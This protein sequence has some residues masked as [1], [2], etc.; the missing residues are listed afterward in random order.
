MLDRSNVLPH[1]LARLAAEEPDA[2]A[3]QDVDGRVQTRRELHETNLRWADA[4]RRLAVQPGEHVVT[5]L[6][7]SFEAFHAWLGLTWIGAVEVPAN[8]MYRGQMLRYLID[9]SDARVLIIS[10]RFVP[11]LLEVAADLA[12]L[13]TVVVPDATVELP[14]LEQTL[15]GRVVRGDEFFAG[16]DPAAPEIAALPGPEYWDIAAIIYTSG[17]TGPSKGVLMP[18]GTLWSFVTTAPDDFVLPG[19]GFYAMYPAFHVSGKAMLYQASVFRARMV[20][21]EQFSIQHFW[22]DVRRFDIAGAGLVGAMAPFLML[23]PE[24]PDDAT[25]PLR[26]VMMGPLVPQVDDF[27]R[28]FGVNVGTGYGMTEIG[29]P[30]ASD[31][32][33]LA[34]ARSCG[35]LR[36]G[37][38]GYEVRIVDEHDQP[39]GPNTPGELVVRT[40][41]PWVINAGYYGKPEATADAWRNGWFHTGDAFVY[42]DDANFYFVDRIKDAIRRRG[43]NISS[44][45][46]EALV[47]QHP[48]VTESAAIGVP[49]EYLED[50][51]KVCVVRVAGSTLTEAELIEFL[52]PHMPKFM[53]PRYVELVDALPKTEGTMRT[54]KYQLRVGALND[55]T[56]DR[57]AAAKTEEAG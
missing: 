31:G 15:G 2:I 10:E 25:T 36:A 1:L 19:E 17:T 27:K 49:S 28:R 57:E 40:R 32:F 44:F 3:M 46:V 9:D 14:E 11:Q 54:Q 42:D 37:W 26:N 5:M 23:A 53:V 12:H 45:E 56:W 6:P 39:L 20:I 30:F 34:N 47:N 43:E 35:K 16:A 18:W 22:D 52:V 24:T 41:E 7:N 38:A 13:R 51:V 4:S 29:A 48:D 21:R 55:R 50:E 33:D 8:T